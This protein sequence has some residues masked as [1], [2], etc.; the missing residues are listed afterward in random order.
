[1]KNLTKKIIV[2]G[3]VFGA[4][5]TANVTNA[6]YNT[7]IPGATEAI[8]NASVN[9]NG[10]ATSAWFEYGT[11]MNMVY[12]TE[13]PHVYVGSSF[14]E[15][16]VSQKI[17]GLSPNNVYYYRAAANNGTVAKGAILSFTTVNNNYATASYNNNTYSNNNVVYTSTVPPVTYNNANDGVN[18]T[19]ITST[20]AIL[21]AVL[22]NP[23][24]QSAQG[25][26]EWGPSTGFGNVTPMTELGTGYT[27]NFSG[28]LTQLTPNTT[29]YFRAVAVLN[30]RTIR[31]ATKNFQTYA[32]TVA[33]VNPTYAPQGPSV[34]TNQGQVIGG[35]PVMNNTTTVFPTTTENQNLSANAFFGA[36]FLPNSLFGWLVLLLIILAV[37]WALRRLSSPTTYVV[38]R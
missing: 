25:Y 8:L 36:S 16:P 37:V 26:F 14:G 17:T 2:L 21:N 4:L 28:T 1:M 27:S 5:L 33:S 23:N 9:P 32:T 10:T 38:Q 7:V 12:F 18:I 24:R 13:T 31:G 11:D 34:V 35:T 30:G 29:Y 15:L 19:N 20:G 6:Q 22:T 3:A